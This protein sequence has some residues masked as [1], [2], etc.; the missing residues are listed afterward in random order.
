MISTVS[1]SCCCR[2]TL[3]YIKVVSGRVSG[4][5]IHL[6]HIQSRIT[7][8]SEECEDLQIEVAD[9]KRIEKDLW[10]HSRVRVCL[11]MWSSW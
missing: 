5:F 9:R 4:A 11:C 2:H 7:E 1:S 8:L 6:V 3:Y 10:K